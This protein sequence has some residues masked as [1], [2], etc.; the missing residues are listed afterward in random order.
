MGA[1][2]VLD[3]PVPL[4]KG[5]R[6]VGAAFDPIILRLDGHI[7]ESGEEEHP[8]VRYSFTALEAGRTDVL[9]KMEPLSGGNPEVYRRV[10]VTVR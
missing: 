9:V 8:R 1:R 7:R 2:I 4:E 5:Y 6:I 3:C 10:G